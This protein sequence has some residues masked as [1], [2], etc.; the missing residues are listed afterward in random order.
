MAKWQHDSSLS[1]AFRKSDI[2]LARIDTLIDL[3]HQKINTTAPVIACDLFSTIDYW[4]CSYKSSSK[5][6][7]DRLP[8]IQALYEPVVRLLCQLMK[9]T[10]IVFH[11]NWSSCSAVKCPIWE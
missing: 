4:L 6:E 8:A 1:L 3:Y 10:V 9:C 5:M 11:G 2:I 7:K